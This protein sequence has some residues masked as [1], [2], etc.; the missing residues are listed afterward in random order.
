MDEAHAEDSRRVDQDVE[1]SGVTANPV[2]EA[3]NIR[4]LGNIRGAG[5]GRPPGIANLMGG[6]EEA[7]CTAA[8]S[9]AK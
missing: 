9:R 6:L 1:L 4:P 5:V 3:G 7:R 2:E 8:P